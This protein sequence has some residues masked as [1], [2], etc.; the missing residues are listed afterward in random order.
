MH[1]PLCDCSLG[2]FDHVREEVLQVTRNEQEQPFVDDSPGRT[3]M[4][5]ARF[6]RWATARVSAPDADLC[7]LGRA[8]PLTMIRQRSATRF[9]GAGMGREQRGQPQR[10]TARHATFG[11]DAVHV[12]VS[13]RRG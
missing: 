2:R 12:S 6:C 7:R 11:S 3:K 10:I 13:P 4:A 1:S 9:G 8:D 5:I